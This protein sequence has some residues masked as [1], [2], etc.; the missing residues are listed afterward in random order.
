MS[1]A[2]GSGPTEVRRPGP[3]LFYGRRL[4]KQM[5]YFVPELV[6]KLEHEALARNVREGN[7]YRWTSSRV[8]H[9]DLAALYGVDVG[10]APK[11]ES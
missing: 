3:P 11:S 5:F 7:P 2:N 8:A 9:E 10:P 1:T 6:E 4:K